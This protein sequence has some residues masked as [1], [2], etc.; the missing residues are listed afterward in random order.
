MCYP[1]AAFQKVPPVVL[2][3]TTLVLFGLRVQLLY[4]LAIATVKRT[5]WWLTTLAAST[6]NVLNSPAFSA[7]FTIATK[8]A[9][10]AM[11]ARACSV[12]TQT[13]IPLT[14]SLA[15][16]D[17]ECVLNCVWRQQQEVRA[18]KLCSGLF[19]T[20][21]QKPQTAVRF[22]QVSIPSRRCLLSTRQL[23]FCLRHH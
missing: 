19:V 12:A 8:A 23:E 1:I 17:T 16:V 7:T 6:Q 13:A 21:M 14:T 15:H 11:A 5:D 2:G 9:D 10:L 22:V 18:V 4:A 3:F 20:L